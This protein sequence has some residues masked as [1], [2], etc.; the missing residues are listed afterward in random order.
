MTSQP[1]ASSVPV[2]RIR[3]IDIHGFHDEDQ[4]LADIFAGGQ[5]TTGVMVAINAEKVL[6]AERNETLRTVIAEARY[7]YP[8][9]IS[10]VRSI[11][12][13]YGR[14]LPRI[15]GIDLWQSL[16]RH[17]ARRDVPVYLLGARPAV[18]QAVTTRLRDEWRVPVA[19]S[20]HGY[21]ADSGRDE[22]ID[23]I[24]RS[25]ARIITVA[26]G[27]PRQEVFM[28]E[29]HRQCPDTLCIGVGGSFDVFSGAVNR[30]PA[31]W[32]ALGLEWLYR[33]LSQPTRL[34]RVARLA[35][36]ARYHYGNH[37]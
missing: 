34:R 8:D 10:V 11:R 3:G 13:K 20:H 35:R 1:P 4:L 5:V 12:R 23:Q 7:A 33:T 14:S 19:G 32:R 28:R 29:C 25:G 21:F 17:A 16:M 18:L 27:S 37:L 15:T 31:S 26:L 30:A 22:I 2:Y 24:R 36:Y 6:A 9:G